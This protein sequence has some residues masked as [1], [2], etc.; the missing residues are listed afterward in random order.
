[1]E[2]KTK[3]G[4]TLIELLVVIAII[5]I[6]AAILF[7][8]FAKVREKAR[9][10]SCLSNEKQIGT[11]VMMYIQDNEETFPL[12]QRNSDA[13]DLT[14][15][16]AA[17]NGVLPA[18]LNP[19]PARNVGTPYGVVTW[20]YL[21]NPYIKGGSNATVANANVVGTYF[22]LQGGVFS[23]PSFP[24]VEPDN[25]GVNMYICADA[26]AWSP[27]G[28]TA[29]DNMNQ[30]PSPSD[31]ILICEKGHT[32]NNGDPLFRSV[33]IDG[34]SY[35][36]MGQIAQAAARDNDTDDG[37]P[38]S[39]QPWPYSDNFPRYRHSGICNFLFADGHAHAMNMNQVVGP[40]NWCKKIFVGGN[41]ATT[42]EGWGGPWGGDTVIGTGNG[43]TCS[44]F[45][46]Q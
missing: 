32:I 38:K 10:I 24:M 36:T 28:V 12:D 39:T 8:V 45:G 37:G 7:P 29:S 5:A 19:P 40:A 33:A 3:K 41:L 17:N 22:A 25:Y 2:Q 42:I 43:K 44:A 20:Q 16:Q 35:I 46:P 27:F 4:F 18:V 14:V 1:M 6:L 21:V 26:S 31:K 30:I 11:G 13:G 34:T 23:C 15:L 9:Q